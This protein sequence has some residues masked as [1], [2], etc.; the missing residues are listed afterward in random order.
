MS[1]I[2][3]ALARTQHRSGAGSTSESALSSALVELVRRVLRDELE[4]RLLATRAVPR[5]PWMTP[6]AAARS[7]GVP[8]KSIRAWVRTGRI[9]KRLK[10]SSA[11]PKQQK[12]LANLDDVIAVAEQAGTG[13]TAHDAGDRVRDRAQAILAARAAKER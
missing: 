10:N 6:P 7:S 11:D 4:A 13:R 9:Q 5:S 8:V 12:Y 1:D 2:V 3:E